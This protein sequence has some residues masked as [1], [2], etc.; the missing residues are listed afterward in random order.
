M[1]IA[2]AV[3]DVFARYGWDAV[4][5]NDDTDKIDGICGSQEDDGGTV[6][7]ACG[8]EGFDGFGEG[9]LL[10]SE[11]RNE[12]ATADLAACFKTSEDV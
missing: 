8:A 10:T 7:S 3:E 1:Q 11:A 12:A 4:A 5:R 2:I 9:V 6:A